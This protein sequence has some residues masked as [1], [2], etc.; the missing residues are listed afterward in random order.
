MNNKLPIEWF[1]DVDFELSLLD[2]S[3]DSETS[4]DLGALMYEDFN[5]Y[6]FVKKIKVKHKSF[7][8]EY[9]ETLEDFIYVKKNFK[10]EKELLYDYINNS[11]LF[12]LKN[13]I[14][15]NSYVDFLRSIWEEDYKDDYET[16]DE[17]SSSETAAQYMNTEQEDKY[18]DFLN[19]YKNF[20]DNVPEN[21][22]LVDSYNNVKESLIEKMLNK[23]IQNMLDLINDIDNSKIVKYSKEK[24]TEI[25]SEIFS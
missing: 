24:L 3:Y 23:S 25:F 6:D 17:F 15:P 13:I 16:F 5:F 7:P 19:E 12:R 4:S 18:R 8:V 10:K 11:F 1:Y 9:I 2:K 22:E 21:I 20:F 14:N